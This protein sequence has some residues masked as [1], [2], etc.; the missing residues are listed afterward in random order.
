MA[1]SLSCLNNNGMRGVAR[2]GFSMAVLLY[3]RAVILSALVTLV[4]CQTASHASVRHKPVR[5]HTSLTNN[6]ETN[7]ARLAMALRHSAT[8]S[9]HIVQFG[10]SHTAADFFTGAL[11]DAFQQRFGNGGVG[12][13]S[14]LTIPGQRYEQVVLPR[15]GGDWVLKTSRHDLDEAFSLGGSY[16]QP[17]GYQRSINIAFRDS[18]ATLEPLRVQAF[19]KTAQPNVLTEQDAH[20]RHSVPLFPGRW[21]YSSAQRLTLPA[22]MTLQSATAGTQLGGWYLDRAHGVVV[23]SI[24]SNGASLSLLERWQ[25]DWFAQL[26]ALH[27]DMIILS[28][29]TNESLNKTL[30]FDQYHQSYSRL[31][32]QLRQAIPHAV[33][34]MVGPGDNASARAGGNCRHMVGLEKV[35]A[36]Q[37]DVARQEHV[38]YWDW[39]AFMGGACSI[40]KWRMRGEGQADRVHLLRP[41]YQRSARGLYK[42]IMS[43]LNM[44]P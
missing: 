10:D 36:V 37:R 32:R 27:P 20:G 30:D 40:N 15:A 43:L 8:R 38:L 1:R 28:Y 34:L 35:I 4:G 33:I 12:F 44:T 31:I 18:S 11:R 24:G 5:V 13:I 17:Q 26:N 16:A 23:S 39:R 42:N 25:D 29:G 2:L 9:V 19:Y 7:V 22:T 41:G 3:Q 14:P 21:G 6:G